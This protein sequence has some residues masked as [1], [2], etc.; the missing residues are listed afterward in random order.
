[1]ENMILTHK[2]QPT[3]GPPDVKLKIRTHKKRRKKVAIEIVEIV[4]NTARALRVTLSLP[5]DASY[6]AA[7]AKAKSL[8]VAPDRDDYLDVIYTV[9]MNFEVKRKTFEDELRKI[10]GNKGN[11]I[12][13]KEDLGKVKARQ[14]RSILTP[15]ANLG[16]NIF[17]TLFLSDEKK[18]LSHDDER[19]GAIVNDAISSVFSRPQIISIRSPRLPGQLRIALFPWAFLYDD[20]QFNPANEATLKPHRFWGF[21]HQIQE[22]IDYSAPCLSLT[23]SPSIL[24]AICPDADKTQYH[25]EPAHAFKKLN[26]NITQVTTVK[27]LGDALKNFT[28]D[29]FY[30]YGHAFHP[31]PP[32][33]TQ[34]RL[35]LRGESLTVDVLKRLYKPAQVNKRFTKDT[36]LTFLNGCQTAPLNVWDDQSFAGYLCDQGKWRVCCVVTVASVP[37]SVAAMF[38][39]HFWKLFLLRKLP[40]GDALHKTRRV[41]LRKWNNPLGLLYT[42]FGSV[43]TYVER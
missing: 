28:D 41:I 8:F 17:E 12:L 11:E 4:E 10:Y 18:L 38:G 7:E 27:E 21:K 24:T 35:E 15:L 43:D 25:S 3:Q 33:Q 36:V 42:V 9:K 37:G 19:H 20:S 40:L 29:C 23:S 6:S 30:F 1:M 32:E 31:D 39:H 16:A 13:G 2:P 14:L 5:L 26:S 22:D 34:S